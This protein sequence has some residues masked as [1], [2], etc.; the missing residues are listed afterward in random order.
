[1]HI[2]FFQRNSSKLWL[3]G[4]DSSAAVTRGAGKGMEG[5]EAE[6]AGVGSLAK[7]EAAAEGEEGTVMEP[8]KHPVTVFHNS[9]DTAPLK[10]LFR[11]TSQA[12]TPRSKSRATT[13][14]PLTEEEEVEGRDS[15]S[16]ASK[17]RCPTSTYLIRLSSRREF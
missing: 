5:A 9:K 16:K 14:N 10:A 1:M 8:R 4:S 7:E 15:T 11:T 3:L 2:F 12:T 13:R 17:S 6:A